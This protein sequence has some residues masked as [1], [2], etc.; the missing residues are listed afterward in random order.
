MRS[1]WSRVIVVCGAMSVAFVEPSPSRAQ[2]IPV[3]LTPKLA[4]EI[5]LMRNPDILR[6]RE[7]VAIARAGV[8]EARLWRN[9]H[10][11][12]F[13]ERY[14][15]FESN[16]GPVFQ[17]SEL[18]VRV[19]QPIEMGGKRAER[20]RVAEQDVEVARWL[21]QDTIRRAELELNIRYYRVVHT[22]AMFEITQEALRRFDEIARLTQ[23]RHRQGEA[24]GLDAMRVETAHPQYFDDLVEAEVALPSAKFA[25]LELLGA[26]DP[27]CPLR[28]DRE[29]GVS[30]ARRGSGS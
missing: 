1:M 12:I 14:P 25:L 8:I 26:T 18:T 23:L 2:D 30:I 5:L 6:V 22:K 21:L 7:N 13:A 28:R 9:P 4:R 16:R 19:G 3:S 17:N 27:A 20:R 24:S 29:P 10:L 15:Q 11:D